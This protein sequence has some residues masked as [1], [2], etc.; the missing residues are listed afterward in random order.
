MPCYDTQCS[1]CGHNGFDLIF[2]S[3]IRLDEAQC[4]HCGKFGTL[5]VVPKAASFKIRGY[6]TANGYSK[7][8][9]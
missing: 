4:Q 3:R 5:C 7:D 9:K 8:R 1:Y 2:K 6:S